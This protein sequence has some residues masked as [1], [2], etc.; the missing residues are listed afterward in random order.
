MQHSSKKPWLLRNFN[1]PPKIVKCYIP[2]PSIF[3]VSQH[4]VS[5]GSQLRRHICCDLQSQWIQI[6]TEPIL[7]TFQSKFR[8]ICGC[9]KLKEWNI[10]PPYNCIVKMYYCC[11]RIFWYLSK[12]IKL[13]GDEILDNFDESLY[14]PHFFGAVHFCLGHFLI[15]GNNKLILSL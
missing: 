2:P 11:G 14:G 6:Q 12:K 9:A 13:V 8:M 3:F 5:L 7:C 10:N 1:F 15:N 4:D